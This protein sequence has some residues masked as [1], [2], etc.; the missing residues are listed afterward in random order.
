MLNSKL[1]LRPKVFVRRA[2][3][4][5]QAMATNTGAVQAQSSHD[6][7][8]DRGECAL[9]LK[10]ACAAKMQPTCGGTAAPSASR[11][12]TLRGARR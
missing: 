11:P 10:L 7:D 4:F 2:V 1:Q 6:C 8:H 12:Q 3:S 9:L 5:L